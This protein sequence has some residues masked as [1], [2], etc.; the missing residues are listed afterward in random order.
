MRVKWTKEKC[1][2][3]A[4]QYSHKW[5]FEQRSPAG[6]AAAR[7][8][9]WVEEVCSHMEVRKL[10]ANTWD[11]ES[12]RLEAL[13]F[14]RRWEFGVKNKGAYTAAQKN[15]WLDDICSHMSYQNKARTEESLQAEANLYSSRTEFAHHSPNAYRVAVRRKLLDK[16]CK[17]YPDKTQSALEYNLLKLIQK[18]YP[19][20]AKQRFGK[21]IIGQPGNFFELDVYI[22]E[23]RKGIEFNGT[24]F[25]SFAGMKRARPNWPDDQLSRY[26][27]IKRDFFKKHDIEYIDIWEKDWLNDRQ[28]CLTQISSFLGLPW[29]S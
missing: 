8:H 28:Q 24:Y 25:H 6:M 9:G 20:A 16:I 5:Q 4:M 27:D 14:N 17:A 21:R 18:H 29:E 3:T 1:K 19:K 13:K 15:G 26:H 2:E 12:C 23:L 10:P 11:K 7:R 22:P